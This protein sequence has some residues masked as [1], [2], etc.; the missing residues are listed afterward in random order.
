MVSGIRF[1]A[2][3][4][5]QGGLT[6]ADWGPDVPQE[7]FAYNS[8]FQSDPNRVG[9]FGSAGA[10]AS[11]IIGQY[12]DR[13]HRTNNTGADLGIMINVKFTGA[14]DAAV[15]GVA[16]PNVEDLPGASGTLLMRFRDATDT[17]VITQNGFLRAIRFVTNEPND[18]LKP[19]N[20]DIRG[21]QAADTHGNAGNSSWTQMS[22]GAGAGSDLSLA[23]QTG[24]TSVHDWFIALS[25][26]PQAVGT[27][28]AFGFLAQIEFL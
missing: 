18:G 4:G 15:S 14:S 1:G 28:A 19:L 9:F 17:L 3:S 20:V 6:Y 8:S 5:I 12:Q 22:D 25:A 26:S 21:F 13:T 23:N 11:V 2:C 16:F 27:N 7:I 24:E 10:P